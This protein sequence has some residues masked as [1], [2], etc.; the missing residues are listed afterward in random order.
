MFFWILY[1][2]SFF[3]TSGVLTSSRVCITSTPLVAE[4]NNAGEAVYLNQDGWGVLTGFF[5]LLWVMSALFPAQSHSSLISETPLSTAFYIS[6]C[7][8][9]NTSTGCTNVWFSANREEGWRVRERQ[10]HGILH[11]LKVDFFFSAVIPL[12]FISRGR[13]RKIVLAPLNGSKSF[14][15]SILSL[16]TLWSSTFCYF[17][18]CVD[19]HFSELCRSWPVRRRLCSKLIG[20]AWRDEFVCEIY[21]C[22]TPV[23][24]EIVCD[25]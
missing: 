18:N 14:W 6:V 1:D 4:V 17:A 5:L 3:K 11:I 16:Q 7:K 19:T 9:V 22:L 10:L 25:C 20:F 2:K 24:S 8:T 15:S 13:L 21:T 23:K 12:T